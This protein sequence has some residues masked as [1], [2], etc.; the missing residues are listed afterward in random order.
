MPA[1]LVVEAKIYD[2]EGFAEYARRVPELV[3]RYG[4]EY[5]VMGGQQEALEGDWSGS[6]I[7]VHRW[8]D[9]AA[10]RA[11]WSSPEYTGAKQLREGTG[12]FRVILVEG[13][14]EQVLES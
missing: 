1:Y 3:A 11:F 7:V 4:G 14:Q 5:I 12:E 6:R 13:S 2:R 9:M 10:A 8:P